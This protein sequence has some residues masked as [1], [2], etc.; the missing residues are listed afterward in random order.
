MDT[1]GQEEWGEY[2]RF[3]SEIQKA[4][5]Y[6]QLLELH[7]AMPAWIRRCFLHRRVPGSVACRRI[8]EWHDRMIK[9]VIQL[10][11]EKFQ[12]RI[13]QRLPA[14]SWIVFGSGGRE[15]PTFWTDQDNGLVYD[16]PANIEPEQV[17]EWFV[18]FSDIIVTGLEKAGYPF[19]EGNVMATNPRWRGSLKKWEK[20]FQTWAADPISQ[21]HRFL[22]IAADM[23]HIYGDPSL[24]NDLRILLSQ[25][26]QQHPGVLK[27]AAEFNAHLPLP[28]G[29]FGQWYKERYGEHAGK[30]NVKQGGYLQL[31]GALR[32]LNCK[33]RAERSSSAER[34]KKLSE[35]IDSLF[36]YRKE[37]QESLDLFLTLRLL[38]HV[39]D[40]VEGKKPE[41]Y[42]DPHRLD[43]QLE[44]QWKKAIKWARWLQQEALKR[45]K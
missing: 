42:I 13:G 25:A 4:L 2:E 24:A 39:T 23:R 1:T 16:Y 12:R 15:E 45:S 27:K 5:D 44:K 40:E 32:I 31:T 34:L 6:D 14:Y 19:C 26:F 29:I 33:Y 28:L 8:S 17:D 7:H 9:R 21:H 22:M 30:V 36:K 38:Q 18:R 43:P 41:D 20:Q 11:E 35:E 10:A 3:I 37:I